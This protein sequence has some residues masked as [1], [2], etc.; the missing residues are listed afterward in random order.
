MTSRGTIPITCGKALTS[1]PV[2]ILRF[3][4]LFR[5][6]RVSHYDLHS[7]CGN[8]I[9]HRFYWSEESRTASEMCACDTLNTQLGANPFI[10]RQSNRHHKSPY[11]CKFWQFNAFASSWTPP[12]LMTRN[13]T[14]PHPYKKEV[15]LVLCFFFLSWPPSIA[16]IDVHVIVLEIIHN[17]TCKV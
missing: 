7:E 11:A 2:E 15:F 6:V 5:W 12:S 14:T 10:P 17:A 16:K 3:F 1:S 4:I 9:P 13:A 8:G